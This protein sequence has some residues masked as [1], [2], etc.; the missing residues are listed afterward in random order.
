MVRVIILIVQPCNAVQC[1]DVEREYIIQNHKK[2][3]VT[4]VIDNDFL[5]RGMKPRALYIMNVLFI[6]T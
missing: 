2:E 5:T 6:C 3:T 4:T 1:I